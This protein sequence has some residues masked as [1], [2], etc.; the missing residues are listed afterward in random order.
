MFFSYFRE[1]SAQQMTF[2]FQKITSQFLIFVYNAHM[3]CFI[4]IIVISFTLFAIETDASERDAMVGGG[5][6]T[7]HV[8]TF[9]PLV[10]F[11]VTSTLTAL[12]TQDSLLFIT[13]TLLTNLRWNIFAVNNEILQINCRL[14]EIFYIS[15]SS[16]IL[17]R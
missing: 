11:F 5:G 13:S 6:S 10:C 2:L 8:S 7:F 17:M 16:F 15:S 1:K 14:F 4:T 3:L 9:S 12:F